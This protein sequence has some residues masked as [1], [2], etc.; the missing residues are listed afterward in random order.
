MLARRLGIGNAD[1]DL[2]PEALNALLPGATATILLPLSHDDVYSDRRFLDEAVTYITTGG[3][4][5]AQPEQK[6]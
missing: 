2:S 6:R 5:R 3:F 4:K 1:I